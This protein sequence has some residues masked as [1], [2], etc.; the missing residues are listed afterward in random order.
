[1]AWTLTIETIDVGQGDSSLIV[2]R[3]PNQNLRRT[4]LIDGGLPGKGEAIETYL[5]NRLPGISIDFIVVSHYEADHIGGIVNLLV[6]DNFTIICG[7]IGDAAAEFA[8]SGNDRESCIAGAAAS[9]YA[10]IMG[11]YDNPDPGGFNLASVA[12]DAANNAIDNITIDIDDDDKAVAYGIRKAIEELDQQMNLND[13]LIKTTAGRNAAARLSAIAAVDNNHLTANDMEDAAFQEVFTL[14]QARVAG[15]P[16][17]ETG[18]RFE[19][20]CM[21]DNGATKCP[22]DYLDAVQGYITM[23][24]YKIKAPGVNRV[25]NQPNL[26]EELL[27]HYGPNAGNSPVNAPEVFLFARMGYIWKAPANQVP[28]SVNPNAQ[29]YMSYALIIRFNNFFFYTGGDL[30]AVGEN[31]IADSVMTNKLPAGNVPKYNLPVRVAAFKCG[32]HGSSTSTSNY[33]LNRVFPRGAFISCG[34][35]DSYD[36]P[37]QSVINSLQ[38]CATMP[39]FYLTAC[40]PQRTYIPAS[41]GGNQLTVFN[42]KSRVAGGI[43]IPPGDIRLTVTQAQ[44]QAGNNQVNSNYQVLYYDYDLAPV[45]ANRVETSNF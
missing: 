7:L 32:H 17:F 11:A 16:S 9:A 3:D 10:T 1:M 27:W 5:D 19:T 45:A 8:A 22:A 25:R 2:A 43:A 35:N 23:S 29:N 20:T 31:L 30:P 44:S 6:A 37:D 33:F 34:Q 26:G 41:T 40:V 14:L 21:F 18:G 38:A 13:S 4:M 36:H 24:S 28:I 42:N 15:Q 39:F 12:E